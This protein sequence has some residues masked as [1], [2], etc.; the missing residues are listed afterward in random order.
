[1]V[2]TPF[3]DLDVIWTESMTMDGLGMTDGMGEVLMYGAAWRLVTG[4]EARR[5]F[6][7]V[8]SESRNA[9]EVPALASVQLGKQLKAVRDARLGEEI[10]RLRYAYGVRG[11]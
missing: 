9:Q 6:T 11:I 10:T 8:E 4:R 5:L 1:M 3:N 7:E 2:A